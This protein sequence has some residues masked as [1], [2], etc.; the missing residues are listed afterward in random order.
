MHEYMDRDPIEECLIRLH[1]MDELENERVI[2]N[3]NV[4]EAIL[5]HEKSEKA[6]IVEEKSI[7]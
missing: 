6:V 1:Y 4:V 7:P 2:S 5:T 3:P